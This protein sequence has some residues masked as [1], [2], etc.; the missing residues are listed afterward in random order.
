MNELVPT[1]YPNYFADILGNVYS[2]QRTKM[3]KKLKPLTARGGYKQVCIYSENAIPK[4]IP[5]HRLIYETFKE[6]IPQGMQIDHINHIRDDNRLENLRVVTPKEN[7][8]NTIKSHSEAKNKYK[9]QVLC[10]E[11]NKK[12][13]SIQDCAYQM[14]IYH[15]GISR[16]CKSKGYY[17]CRGFHFTYLGEKD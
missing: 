6:K 15:Q 12:F 14:Q 9:K 7:Q 17:A 5:I 3:P 8:A 11:T 10:I 1:K 2:I 16:S 4:R 13:K